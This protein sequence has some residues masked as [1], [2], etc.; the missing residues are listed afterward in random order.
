MSINSSLYENWIEKAR[1]RGIEEAL[2]D[3]VIGKDRSD[4]DTIADTE[5]L[6]ESITGKKLYEVEYDDGEDVIITLV[7]AHDEAYIDAYMAGSDER[8]P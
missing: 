3:L 4:E 1:K 7:E 2:D 5:S 8:A 6:V